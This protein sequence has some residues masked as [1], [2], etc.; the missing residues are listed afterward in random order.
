MTKPSLDIFKLHYRLVAVRP[1]LQIQSI[2]LT[3]VFIHK[4]SAELC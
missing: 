1:T 3:H 2:V 4:V